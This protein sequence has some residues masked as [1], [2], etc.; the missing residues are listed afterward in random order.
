MEFV[1]RHC[2]KLTRGVRYRVTSE[3]AGVSL[4]DMI[5][6]HACSEQAKNL[7]LKAEE[8]NPEVSRKSPGSSS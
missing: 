7:G 4:L 6:C 2:N 5:V 1:C 3:E 8:I